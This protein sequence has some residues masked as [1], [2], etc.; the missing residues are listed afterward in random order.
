MSA[1]NQDKI[2]MAISFAWERHDGQERKY[3]GH[4]YFVHCKAVAELVAERT[5]DEDLIVAAYLH[6]TVEDTKTT[7]DEIKE[8]FGLRVAKLVYELTEEFTHAAYPQ[9]NRDKRKG[10]EL[11]RWR[12]A[13]EGA[14]LIKLCDLID[15]TG[16]IVKYDPKFA[17][18]YLREKADLLE[19]MGW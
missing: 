12:C 4:P 14:K 3:T 5:D 16:T 9:W 10:Q 15:N 17:K 2:K 11:A 18:T 1:S 7:I 8:I 13:S 19:A 6:D